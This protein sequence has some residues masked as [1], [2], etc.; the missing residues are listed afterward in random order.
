EDALAAFTNL[1]GT[2]SDVA[3]LFGSFT[4][5]AA[6]GGGG[7]GGD[8]FG[9]LAAGTLGGLDMGMDVGMDMGALGLGGSG[10][11]DLSSIRLV[12]L[13]DAGGP[14]VAVQPA[15]QIVGQL[16]GAPAAP[17]GA[18]RRASQSSDEMGDIPL[19]QLG[20]T[21]APP[22]P[23][24]PLLPVAP[25]PPSQPPLPADSAVAGAL[26][27]GLSASTAPAPLPPT[28]GVG[29]AAIPDAATAP[30]SAQSVESGTSGVES[31]VLA[32]RP[33]GAGGA[34][35]ERL[36]LALDRPAD[37]AAE[38]EAPPLAELERI[39]AQLCALLDMAARTIRMLTGARG[40]AGADAGIAATV[41]AFMRSVAAI[42]ADLI[43]QHRRLAAR[44][45]P[46]H[47]P[48]RFRSAA[49][50]PERDLAVWSDAAALLADALESSL[51]LA[52]SR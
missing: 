13:G 26:A 36:R 15:A 18:S 39:E 8:I 9:Q 2:D 23:A 24:L 11:V 52:A 7:A 28:Y 25:V 29:G 19:A 14:A 21:P 31:T 45:I 10:A 1:G 33:G 5:D 43:R 44:G 12:G 22:P 6:V 30:V 20:L 37:Q 51:R 46:T 35:S 48:A 16:L 40:A 41:D 50:A 38:A 49:A 42:H 3:G 47:I 32:A 34:A 27:L 17:L 4:N